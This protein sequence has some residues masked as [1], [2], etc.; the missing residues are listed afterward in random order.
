MQNANANLML[1]NLKMS[2]QQSQIRSYAITLRPRTGVSDE[3]IQTLV[4]W[5][6]KNCEYYFVITEMTMADRHVHAG[7]F[8]KKKKTKSNFS[9]DMLRLFKDLDVEEKSVF[10]KGIRMM[11]NND[12]ID[13]Y[14][15]KNTDGETVVIERSLPEVATLNS[16]Y[17]ECPAPKKKGPSAVDPFYANLEKLWWEHKRPIEETNPSNLRNF[18]MNMMNNERKIRVIADNKKIFSISCAL[19]RYINKESSF[20]V[21]PD[22]FHQD[23]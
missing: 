23:V 13:N 11:Y 4:K 17:L 9:T 3:Q 20:F 1:I 14:L 21:E 5:V 22:P 19:S 18:L 10:R 12:F 16:Y 6:K 8:L 7:L 15:T 2:D